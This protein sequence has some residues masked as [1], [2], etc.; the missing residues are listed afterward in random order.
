M[1]DLWSNATGSITKQQQTDPNNPAL[2]FEVNAELVSDIG[3]HVV[4]IHSP[5]RTEAEITENV[6]A[7]LYSFG[8]DLA[9]AFLSRGSLKQ[10][11]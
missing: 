8:V 7:Q 11:V 9:K 2:G 3:R 5:V 10:K 1:D 4:T 6:R